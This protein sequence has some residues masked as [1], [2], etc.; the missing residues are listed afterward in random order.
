MPV[1]NAIESINMSPRKVIRN[2][3]SFAADEAV[4]TLF[5]LTLN[6]INEKRSMPIRDCKAVLN[7]FTIPFEERPT[8]N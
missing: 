4:T 8:P 7:R 6:N 5:Y 3:S 1:T 2:S